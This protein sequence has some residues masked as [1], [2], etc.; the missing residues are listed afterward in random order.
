MNDEP[1]EHPGELESVLRV[2]DA[3]RRGAQDSH[4]TP[5]KHFIICLNYGLSIT[6][7]EN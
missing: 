3:L 2:V 6:Y 5:E 1:V 7:R 4:L